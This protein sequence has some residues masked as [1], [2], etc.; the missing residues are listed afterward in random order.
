MTV[1]MSLL[2]SVCSSRMSRPNYRSKP[3]YRSVTEAGS[4]LN[5]LSELKVRPGRMQPALSSRI[6]V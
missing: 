6:I 5:R 3:N 1:K 2:K 4:D